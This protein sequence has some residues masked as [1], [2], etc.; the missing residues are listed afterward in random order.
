MDVENKWL[1][2]H[3]IQWETGLPDSPEA[4]HDIKT[5]CSAF[6]AA[7]CLNL[8]MY[9][10]RPPQHRQTLLANA[11]F[12][13]LLK[14]EA[15]NAGWMPI[16]DSIFEKAQSFANSGYVVIAVY[17]NSDPHLSGHIALVMP[18]I[19]TEAQLKD[20]GPELIQAG[21]NNHNDIAFRKGFKS[22]IS[23]WST[24]TNEIKFYFNVQ[25]A[26]P[27]PIK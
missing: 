24:V 20:E 19:K 14:E 13:W 22:H 5:H 8:N 26:F 2:G 1:A 17:K 3:H 25:K 23:D 4:N 10:L 9:I 7:A 16:N 12:N 21:K 27:T 15:K 6:V 11:Q 18:A